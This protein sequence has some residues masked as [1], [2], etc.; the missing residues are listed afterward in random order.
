MNLDVN[1]KKLKI[2]NNSDLLFNKY[3]FPSIDLP[4]LLEF[5]VKN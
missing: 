5:I 1:K 4:Y 3:I 2:L